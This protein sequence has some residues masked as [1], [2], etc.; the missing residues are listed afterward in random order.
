[1]DIETKQDINKN[2][3]ENSSKSD[4]N[5][6]TDKNEAKTEE[7]MLILGAGFARTGTTSLKRALEILGF[8]PC[9]H[10][11]EVIRYDLVDFWEKALSQDGKNINW[12]EIFDKF[13]GTTD[14]PACVF[15]QDILKL[16]PNSKVILTTR[17]PDRWYQSMKETILTSNNSQTIGQRIN[18][19]IF[20]FN[21]RFKAMTKHILI[22]Q[23]GTDYSR[24]NMVKVFNEHIK[25]VEKLCPKEKLLKFEVKQ[26]WKP[27]CEFL[28]KPIPDCEFPNENNT[29]EMKIRMNK[30]NYIGNFVLGATLLVTVGGLAWIAKKFLPKMLK[31]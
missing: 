11:M 17:D 24:D 20:S 16:Y 13:S 8:N 31:R 21:R 5:E 15:W 27:L 12:R 2:I 30:H 14:H 7:K 23:F 26:G 22:R 25:N 10:M 6:G 9:H 3:N 19:F 29:D 28:G 4:T 18:N 1:M